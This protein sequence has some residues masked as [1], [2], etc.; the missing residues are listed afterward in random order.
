MNRNFFCDLHEQ[1]QLF[2]EKIFLDMLDDTPITYG[3]A[4]V[5]TAKLA[6]RLTESGLVPGDRLCAQV[7]KSPIVVILYLACLRAG[8]IYLPLNTAYVSSE[9]NHF[10]QDAEPAMVICDPEKFDEISKLATNSEIKSVLTLDANGNGTLMDGI[11]KYSASQEV[12]VKQSNDVALLI[13]TSGTTG[14]PKGS[15]ITHGNIRTNAHA[16]NQLWEWSSE[17]VLLHVLPLFHVHGLFNA[18]HSPMLKASRIIFRKEFSVRETI[19]L[20]PQ[21]TV[22]MAVPTI[23]SRLVSSSF[24]TKELCKNFRLFISGSAPLLPQTFEVFEEQTGHRILER[25][26]MTEAVM[27]TSNPVRGKRIAGTVGKALAD[28]KLQVCDNEGN[29]LKLGEI[30]VLEI[31][32]PNVFKGYWRNEEATKKAIRKNGYFVSGDLATIDENGIVSIV[33]RKTD[34]IISAGFNIYPAEVE[35]Q[36]NQIPGVKESAVFGVPHTDLGEAVV[37]VIVLNQG[38]ELSE[39][40][41]IEQLGKHLSSFKLPR[42]VKFVLELPTNAMGK[43]EKKKLRV[44]YNH[45][46]EID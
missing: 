6:N 44:E 30:G 34:L 25:Y 13:Y 35:E 42:A 11:D 38:G 14:K 40:D 23:Y 41:V 20:I 18:L 5:L 24:L 1:M 37:A 32:G 22:L 26:G 45:L 8:V 15:M 29:V 19:E 28:V 39:S 21:A 9:L 3:D 16:L 36:L 43:V 4:N 12:A 33:G 2:E 27:I 31:K 7:K 17:D 46:F 10:F